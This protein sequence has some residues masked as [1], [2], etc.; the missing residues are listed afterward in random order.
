MNIGYVIAKTYLLPFSIQFLSFVILNGQVVFNLNDI[1]YFQVVK[2]FEPITLENMPPASS[3]LIEISSDAQYLYEMANAISNGTVPADLS[4]T[5]PGP[6]ANARWLIKACRLLRLYVATSEPS[7]SL[8]TMVTYIVRV[9]TSMY[10]NIKHYNS[11][12]YGSVLYHKLIRLTQQNLEFYSPLCK[13]VID[14]IEKIH[15]MH[16]RKMSC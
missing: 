15:I 3:N 13:G 6:I 2:D 10:F 12:V 5:K 16:I 11:V 8:K 1:F 14:V 7:A 9:Y 4:N